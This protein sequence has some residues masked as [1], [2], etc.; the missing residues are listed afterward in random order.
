MWI[1]PTIPLI[2]LIVVL[3]AFAEAEGVENGKD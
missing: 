2:M 3:W 1:L